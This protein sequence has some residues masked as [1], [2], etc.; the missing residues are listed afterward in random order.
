MDENNSIIYGL[1][2]QARALTSQ[3]AENNEVRFFI[4]TQTLKPTNQVH[5]VELNEETSALETTIFSHPWGEIWNLKSC[6]HDTNL[7]SSCYNTQKGSQVIMQ[8]ALLKLPE[9]TV[10]EKNSQL[11]FIQFATSEILETEEYGKEIKTTEFH[12]TDSNLLGTVIDNRILI[13]NRGESKTRVAA[14]INLKNSPKF[15]N[16]KWSQHHQGNQFIAL[17]ESSIRSYDIRDTNHCAWVIE[18]AH[19]QLIRDLDC[20]PNKQCHIATGGD[21]GSLKIWDC[22]NIKEPVFVRTD[23]SHWIWSVRFNTFHDQLILTSSS[24]CKTILTCAGSV[25]SDVG[26]GGGAGGGGDDDDGNKE[27]LPDGL[28]QTFEQHEDSVYCVEWSSADPWIFASLS[29]DGRMILSKVPKQYKFQI[30]L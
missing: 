5:L 18:D 21:D 24:D 26:S 12:P 11:D 20:N 9:I 27:R 16:G 19:T 17:Y 10:D 2:S 29:Y 13:F 3:L 1:E 4:A 22:R 14:E 28:L 30:L 25:S 15:S 8:T 7:L 23:H 6:P